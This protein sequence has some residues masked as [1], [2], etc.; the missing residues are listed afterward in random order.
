M[1]DDR[2]AF[3]T[4]LEALP[5]GYSEG[6]YG[7]RRYGVTINRSD[8]GRRWWLFGRELGGTD[9]ISLN[10]YR[11]VGGRIALRPCEMPADKVIAF[12]QGYSP[13]DQGIVHLPCPIRAEPV[14]APP[15]S[16]IKSEER[17]FGKLRTN[18]VSSD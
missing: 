10:L 9:I 16:G 18:G 8:D 6:L 13:R 1:P 14:E 11:T 5:S 15:S 2:T 4:A 3:M 12:V 17:P 7:G